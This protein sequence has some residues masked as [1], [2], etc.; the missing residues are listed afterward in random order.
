M[1]NHRITGS[2]KY[3]LGFMDSGTTFTYFSSQLW[4][5]LIIHFDWFCAEKENNCLGRR[6]KALCFDFSEKKHYTTKEYFLSF[7]ILRFHVKV[8]SSS[9]PVAL[10][11]FPSEYLYREASNLYCIAAES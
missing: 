6:V 1:N 7:P 4:K 11:W 9:D 5:D 8:D 2:E 10:N 3:N